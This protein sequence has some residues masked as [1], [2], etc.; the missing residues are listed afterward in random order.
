MKIY[1]PLIA[2][3]SIILKL[4]YEFKYIVKKYFSQTFQMLI[5]LK[6]EY[7]I[8]NLKFLELYNIKLKALRTVYFLIEGFQNLKNLDSNLKTL[9]ISNWRQL[10]Q[11]RVSNKA[12]EIV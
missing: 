10:K 7:I 5:A 8:L 1:F 2:E 12:L 3:V 4:G 11:D 6:I 9:V